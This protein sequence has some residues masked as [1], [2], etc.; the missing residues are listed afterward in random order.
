MKSTKPVKKCVIVDLTNIENPSDV[1]AAFVEAKCGVEPITKEE[2]F[3]YAMHVT[4][5]M[6]STIVKSCVSL[7][8]TQFYDNMDYIDA[9]IDTIESAYDNQEDTDDLVIKRKEEEKVEK[10]PNIF[11]RFWNWITRKK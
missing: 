6:N 5:L 10:K 11:K 2:M 3:N 9:L 1:Y 7:S 4:E 8:K